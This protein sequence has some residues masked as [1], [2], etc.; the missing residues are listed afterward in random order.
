M[1]LQ[2]FGH[3]RIK[4]I[5]TNQINGKGEKQGEEEVT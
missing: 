5:D 4:G 2:A 3:Q 1:E